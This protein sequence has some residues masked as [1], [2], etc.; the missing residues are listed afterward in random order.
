MAT[1]LDLS[2]LVEFDRMHVFMH[3]QEQVRARLESFPELLDRLD[4]ALDFA[5]MVGG[6]HP[7]RFWAGAVR[8][9]LSELVAIDDLQ[10]AMRHRHEL[11]S[12]VSLPE[13]GDPLLCTL[14][15]LRH[16]QLHLNSAIVAHEQRD[17]LWGN[18]D[19]PTNAVPVRPKIYFITNLTPESFQ[20]LRNA[21]HYD[22]RDLAAAVEWL[23]SMQKRWG[24]T[25]CIFRA[26]TT[27]SEALARGLRKAVS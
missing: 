8:A 7:P 17:L 11:A 5:A 24:I 4:N 9:S 13:N 19:D 10:K 20:H 3:L 22:A 12:V 1:K 2:R 25:E 18:A 27:Y 26:V 23:D 16:M 6:D 15:E 21:R 14:R